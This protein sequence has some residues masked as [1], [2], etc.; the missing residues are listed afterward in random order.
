MLR[1]LWRR[2]AAG[3]ILLLVVLSATFVLLHAAPGDPT[4]VFLSDHRVSAETREAIRAQYGLDQPLWRQ[5]LIW[6]GSALQGD[7]GTS[8]VHG[9]GAAQV[10]LSKLPATLLLVAAGI[11]VEYSLGLGFGIAAALHPGGR[12]ER[13][14][15][16][17]S[18]I[19]YSI[20]YFWLAIVLIDVLAVRTGWF[21]INMMRSDNAAEL[22]AW[23]R[24]VDL[25]HHLALPALSLGLAQFGLVSRFVHS[26]LAE[27]LE[28]DYVRTARASGLPPLR[29]VWVHGMKNAVGPLLQ[30]FG[31]GLPARL[32]GAVLLE[33][34]FSWPGVG[35]AI[36]NAVLQRDYPVVL[37]STVFSGAVVVVTLLV[38]DLVHA[39]IDPRVRDAL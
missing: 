15:R 1:F 18:L 10:L 16:S 27:V 20:P 2:I 4:A 13:W 6:M 36:F 5:F 7:L 33:V 22:G 38:V 12:L 35:Q 30:R 29:I 9:R 25:L 17:L 19:F 31:A 32:S 14:V 24:L 23:A 28:Q 34:I 3:I 8:I 26:G 21:P 39:W 37:A 11:L